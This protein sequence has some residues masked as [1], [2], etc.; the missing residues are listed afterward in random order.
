[1]IRRQAVVRDTV[2]EALYSDCETYRYALTREWDATR[3]RLLYIMLNPST[4]TEAQ[5][6]PT[7]ER[8]ERRARQLGYGAFRACNL[9]ALRQTDPALMRA[10]PAPEGPGNMGALT[11]GAAWAS[12]VLCAWGVHGA[13]RGQGDV[14][15]ERLQNSGCP[16]LVLGET[17]DG[18]PRHPLY[19]PYSAQ[20]YT[21][22]GR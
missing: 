2:S 10:H 6:D 17:R 15:A 13:Y 8:C 19:L 9:F 21:W 7:I 11:D 12:D 14:V 4:A 22:S 3:P 1:M 16:L 5:N 20:P 18:H